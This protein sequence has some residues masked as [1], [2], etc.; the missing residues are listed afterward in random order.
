MRIGILSTADGPRLGYVV[1]ALR[2]QDIAI[3]CILVDAKRTT[4]RERA[5]LEERTE[6]KLPPIPLAA[7]DRR[8]IPCVT[9]GRH[10]SEACLAEIR[11]RELDIL[12]N[13][14]TP[15][16]LEPPML[17]APR[18]GIVNCHPG[19][20]PDFRGC[21]CVEWAIYLD[22]PI[23]NTVHFMNEGIDEGPIIVK[24]AVS[25]RKSDTYSDARVAVYRAGFR[26][27]AEGLRKTVNEGLRPE[28]LP[29]QGP[30]R[31]FPVIPEHKMIEM[32]D[33][34]RRGAYAY[35]GRPISN[36]DD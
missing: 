7:L 32:C 19:L 18:I 8:D 10:G 30:G 11:N 24:E 22:E 25:L 33:K 17:R 13:A 20:L 9:V 2:E 15:R 5:F 28:H 31:Y 3:A 14:G 36:G 35:Q 21:T 34:L 26:L 1:S 23:G 29:P 12:V 27:L 16:I 4:E 6:G